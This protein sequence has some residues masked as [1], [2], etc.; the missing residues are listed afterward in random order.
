MKCPKCGARLKSNMNF[1]PFC[2]GKMFEQGTEYL[3]KISCQGPR[4]DEKTVMKVFL[5]DEKLY[6]VKPGESICFS[7]K[8]G[9]HVIKFRHKIRSKTIQLQLQSN[10][11]IK[12][13][14]NT[15]TG[16]IETNVNG[17]ED[18]A[19]PDNKKTFAGEPLSEPVL[20][21]ANKKWEITSIDKDGPDYE[22][23]ASSGFKEGTLYL[24]AER[25]EFKCESDFK[26]DVTEYKNV[27]KVTRKLGS[28]AFE[29]AGKIH[30]VYSIPKESYN[31][32][33]AYLTNHVEAIKTDG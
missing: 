25:C 13:Y 24:F 1:C 4:D 26:V 31:E 18:M 8:A 11:L 28:V 10:F 30:K 15:I 32:I 12:T 5:D 7:A 19:D 2:G 21:K 27:L 29:C 17:I 33:M 16:L 14:Y 3:I 22:I 23:K 6:E 20:T 9:Y